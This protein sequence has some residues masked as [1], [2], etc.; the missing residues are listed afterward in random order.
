MGTTK[1]PEIFDTVV[2][3]GCSDAELCA[4]GLV[5]WALC[6]MG[7]KPHPNFGKVMSLIAAKLGMAATPENLM[8]WR[9]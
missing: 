1:W 6:E 3:D 5:A 4:D 7:T 2:V 9:E 8:N